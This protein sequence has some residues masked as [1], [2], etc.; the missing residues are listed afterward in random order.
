MQTVAIVIPVYKSTLEPFEQI[1]LQQCLKTLGNYPVCIAS[2]KGIDLSAY[3]EFFNKTSARYFIEYFNKSSFENV[4]GYNRL[5]V[6]NEFYKRFKSF[7]YILI[8][9]LDVFI[10]NDELLNWCNKGYSYIGAPWIANRNSVMVFKG[11]GNGGLSLRKVNDHLKATSLFRYVQSPKKLIREYYFGKRNLIEYISLTFKLV[12]QLT[13]ANNT[14]FLFNNYTYNEDVFWCHTIAG[15]HSWY[16]IP[17]E[18]EALA[19]AF[20]MEAEYLYHQNNNKLPFGCHAWHRYSTSFWKPIIEN[21][22]Y[23]FPQV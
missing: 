9:Q 17:K 7:Q 18:K 21:E 3:D 15:L 23:A 5:L 19:F 14:F 16:R 13:F 8:H 2:Y 11:V 1:S 12:W 10:F 4:V 22:G 6:G 20:E